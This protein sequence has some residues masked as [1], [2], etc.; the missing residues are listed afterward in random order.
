LVQEKLSYE[1]GPQRVR[2]GTVDLVKLVAL[3]S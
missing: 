2:M 1:E 3:K